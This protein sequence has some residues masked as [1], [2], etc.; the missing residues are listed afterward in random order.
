MRGPPCA[1]HAPG[2]SSRSRW[3]SARSSSTRDAAPAPSAHRR[4]DARS[5]STARWS[6][7]TRPVAVGPTRASCWPT[8]RSCPSETAWPISC[9][10]SACC[11]GRTIPLLHCS[12]C[13]ASAAPGG[14]L[15]VT[16]TDWGTF[17]VDHPDPAAAPTPRRRRARVGAA[18]PARPRP[19]DDASP[20]WARPTSHDRHDTVTITAWDPDDPAAAR[21][22][23]RP[24]APLDRGCSSTPMSPPSPT[25]HTPG[26]FRAS[27]TI[28]TC[29]ARV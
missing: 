5:T 7:S 11:S 27:V 1:R 18:R 14:W 9:A 19:A 3:T 10:S 25:R 8:S 17:T 23:T 2:C 4:P 21:R 16:D 29:I 6:C 26:A 28:V 20:H 12:N 24:P 15:A 13:T 22:P